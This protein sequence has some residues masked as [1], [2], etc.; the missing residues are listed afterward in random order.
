MEI[1]LDNIYFLIAVFNLLK[2]Y[3][4]QFIDICISSYNI[5]YVFNHIF[6]CICSFSSVQVIYIPTLNV[7]LVYYLLISINFIYYLFII[8][9]IYIKLLVIH[10]D[11]KINYII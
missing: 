9:Y 4:V 11:V 2:M 1:L 5:I 10:Y 7:T 3:D 8:L 6:S